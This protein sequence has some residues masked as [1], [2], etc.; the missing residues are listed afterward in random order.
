ML[1][2]DCSLCGGEE[3]TEDHL[4][5]KCPL[6]RSLLIDIGTWWGVDASL[7]QQ[8]AQLLQWGMASNFKKDKLKA[9]MAVVYTYMWLLWKMRNGKIFSNLTREKEAMVCSQI[10]ALFFLD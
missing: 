5:V 8:L 9:F 7:V 3:E 10:Q 4:F 2:L 6:A 1:S